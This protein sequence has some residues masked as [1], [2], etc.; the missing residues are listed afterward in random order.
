MIGEIRDAET[1]R[2]AMQAAITG[3]LVFSTI[4]TRNTAGTI[5]RLLDL[6]VKPYLVVQALHL[7]LAQRLVRQL[8]PHCKAGYAPTREELDAMGD[9]ANGVSLVFRPGWLPQVPWDRL[10]WEKSFF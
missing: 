7:V 3:Q 2:I 9:M 6:G 4:H 5:F 8:C 10:S 1:A